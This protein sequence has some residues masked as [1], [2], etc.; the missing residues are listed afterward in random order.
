FISTPEA[1]PFKYVILCVSLCFDGFGSGILAMLAESLVALYVDAAE[2]ARVMAIQHMIIM[3]VTSPFG[4]IGGL[5][6]EISRVL[7]FV[8][9]I[10]LLGTG[11][12]VTFAYYAKGSRA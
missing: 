7:P 11:F 5:L 12:L 3:L 10:C 9:N 1:G 8:L 2:R 4:W 6:S